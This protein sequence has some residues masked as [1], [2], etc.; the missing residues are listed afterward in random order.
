MNS[1]QL[2]STLKL[3]LSYTAHSGGVDKSIMQLFHLVANK[4]NEVVTW[5]I[6]TQFEEH[7]IKSV[8]ILSIAL[9]ANKIISQLLINNVIDH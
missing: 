5:G 7:F 6:N 4:T 1:N 8:V 3:T 9:E 2:Y